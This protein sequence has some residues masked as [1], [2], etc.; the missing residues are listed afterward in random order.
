MANPIADL[1]GSASVE[2]LTVPAGHVG[3]VTSRDSVK[4][5]LPGLLRWLDQ[6]I[7]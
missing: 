1:V 5:T 4:I 2:G 7:S 6:P 3:L